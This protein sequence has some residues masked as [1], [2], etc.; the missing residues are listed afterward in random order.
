MSHH[1]KQSS[2]IDTPTATLSRL[3]ILKSGAKQRENGSDKTTVPLPTIHPSNSQ[4]SLST[5]TFDLT[6]LGE[7]A[8]DVETYVRNMLQKLPNEDAVQQLHLNLADSKDSVSQELQRNVYRNYNEFVVISKEITK[9]EGDMIA[10]R[11]VLLELKEV[12]E[13]FGTYV[14]DDLVIPKEEEEDEPKADEAF[15][16]KVRSEKEAEDRQVAMKGFYR[17]IDGLSKALPELSNRELIHDGSPLR[18]WDINPNTYKQ[19]DLVFIHVLSDAVVV[20]TWKK[21]MISGKNRLVLDRVFPINEIGFIDMKDSPEMMSAFKILKGSETF[22]YRAETL[23]EKRTLLLVITKITNEIVAKKKLELN[24]SKSP[25]SAVSP[26]AASPY[27]NTATS[28]LI[29]KVGT[30][31]LYQDG[32]SDTDYR[33]LLELSDELDVLI[34]QRDFG[35]AITA[36]ERAR[37]IIAACTGETPRLN[38]LRTNIDERVTK[39]ARLVSL[40]L[41]SPAATKNQIQED[42]K[43]LLRL[44]LGDQA[45]DIYLTARSSTIKHRLRQLQF[46]GDIVSYMIDYSEVFFRLIKN[47]CDWFGVSFHDASMASGFMKWIHQEIMKF[48]VIFRKQT[49][50]L[51]HE[52]SVIAECVITAI[53][54]CQEL[55]S[56]GMDL[57]SSFEVMIR[58]DLKKAIE[59]HTEQCDGRIFKSAASDDFIVLPPNKELFASSNVTFEIPIP[60]MSRSGTEFYEVLSKFGSDVGILI[61]FEVFIL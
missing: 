56:V 51:D 32:L 39:L 42:I 23:Q 53:E 25:T 26:Y 30:K 43:R 61:S 5:V 18:I 24:L 6:R 7:E 41:K 13:N 59:T 60:A 52:F 12:R 17:D 34:A 47:T 50:D 58:K 20:T 19:K 31:K 44:G 8:F 36:V 10:V 11:R 15:R 37:L 38:I 3:N 45:R 22:L 46:N 55:N 33:W 4:M 16:L 54:R 27:S 29:T 21:N 14:I 2:S 48:A 40:D 1:P 28:P 9:L 57:S 49:F 35:Q